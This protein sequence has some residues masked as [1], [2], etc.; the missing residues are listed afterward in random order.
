M[1]KGTFIALFILLIGNVYAQKMFE[2]EFDNCPLKFILEDEEY[3]IH[4]A[5]DD[6][7]MVMDFLS[8]LEE[9]QLT[10]LRG[11]IMFQVMV[12]TAFNVCCVSYTNK[13]TIS[14]KKL[15][16]PDR[17]LQMKGWERLPACDESENI[18][19]LVSMLF[20]KNEVTVVRTAYNRN[21]GRRTM[22]SSVYKRWDE[23][24]EDSN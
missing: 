16:V 6:S 15:M 2:N 23:K 13:S 3:L 8:G 14:D 5:P 4:Y 11:G 7:I 19:A 18:C 21:R 10:K 9:K 20:D 1:I 17:L 22:H 12:D 24:E